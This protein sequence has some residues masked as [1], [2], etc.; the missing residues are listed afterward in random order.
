MKKMLLGV[1]LAF[2]ML[3]ADEEKVSYL[4]PYEPHSSVSPKV[5]EFLDASM[6]SDL[7]QNTIAS[8]YDVLGRKKKQSHLKTPYSFVLRQAKM[9]VLVSFL[10]IPQKDE[11][12][13]SAEYRFENGERQYWLN[14]VAISEEAYFNSIEINGTFYSPSY[15]A[16]LTAEEI[17]S[18]LNGATPI[19][20]SEIVPAEDAAIYSNI[21]DTSTVSTWAFTNGYKGS[22]I[23]VYFS[24][25]GCPK[26]SIINSSN[27]VQNSSCANGVTR[28]ATSMVRVFQTTAPNAI[29][30]QY[31]RGE[32]PN[33]SSLN[34]QVEI[35]FHSYSISGDSAYSVND[36][37]LDNFIYANDITSFVAA[38]NQSSSTGLFYVTSPGKALNAVT[39][40]GVYPFTNNYETISRWKN[41]QVKNQKPEIAT[42]D[43]FSFPNDAHFV[44]DNGSTYDG[45]TRGTSAATAFSAGVLADILQQHPF[46]KHHP[47]MAKALMITASTKP[48]GNASSYDQDNSSKAAKGI[49]LY[50]NMGWNTRSR[51]WRGANSCCFTG[52]SIVFTESNIVKNKRYR[53][54]ISWIVPGS[55]VYSNKKIS[56]DI[57]LYVI[58]DGAV[59]ASSLS[60]KNPFEVVDF[61]TSS[62]SNLKIRIKRYANS[63][64][65]NVV[66]G[67]NMWHE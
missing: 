53:I 19:Y 64:S 15:T 35:G 51:Y 50:K 34:P 42:Y 67:Y 58:Q 28:H 37:N 24:E 3:W 39:V 26:L 41:S 20:I 57:D 44:D 46:F 6:A 63:G 49:P 33:I 61:T 10:D 4:P 17:I 8:S 59:I 2:S 13:V 56:Q 11:R 48:I 52:D 47:E 66:L 12:T 25:D 7:E 5:Q 60:A 21:L 31:P 43:Y 36:R 45:T 29:L 14:G 54:A 16:S 40:G 62:S 30:Y 9:D 22:G 23:G 55:Y 1:V 27:F 65:G 38:G 32:S 18:L